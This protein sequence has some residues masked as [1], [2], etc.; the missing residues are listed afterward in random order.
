MYQFPVTSGGVVGWLPLVPLP[1]P[2][3]PVRHSAKAQ[4]ARIRFIHLPLSCLET[5]DLVLRSY[6]PHFSRYLGSRKRG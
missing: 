4:I 3:H 1:T 2:V 6:P 5:A